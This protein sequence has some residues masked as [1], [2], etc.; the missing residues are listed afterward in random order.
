MRLH[1][2]MTMVGALLA[3]WGRKGELRFP[4]RR[5]QPFMEDFETWQRSARVDT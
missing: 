2:Q 4:M 5:W 3:Y 1:S